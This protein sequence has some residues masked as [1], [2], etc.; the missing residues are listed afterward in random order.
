[1][2]APA[3]PIAT[4]M[5][6]IVIRVRYCDAHCTRPGR[7]VGTTWWVVK[8]APRGTQVLM[9]YV[10]ILSVMALAQAEPDTKEHSSAVIQERI[11]CAAPPMMPW[12]ERQR[13]GRST[14]ASSRWEVRNWN[15]RVVI[16]GGK[17]TSGRFKRGWCM[18]L[19]MYMKSEVGATL[20][21]KRRDGDLSRGGKRDAA[22][23]TE[24]KEK[25]LYTGAT[26]RGP[27][28]RAPWGRVSDNVRPRHARYFCG[29]KQ[30]WFKLSFVKRVRAD[31]ESTHW[32]T[33]QAVDAQFGPAQ[34]VARDLVA[35]DAERGT[36]GQRAS[37]TD[38]SSRN[39]AR[40]TKQ[41]GRGKDL[42]CQTVGNKC[43]AFGGIDL[44]VQMKRWLPQAHNLGL[45]TWLAPVP[46][47]IVKAESLRVD[48]VPICG[49]VC[50]ATACEVRRDFQQKK[51][52]PA[53]TI[54]AECSRA[55]GQK[56]I[57][58]PIQR[59][60]AA[61]TAYKGYGRLK[62][63]TGT[64]EHGQCGMLACIRTK[65]QRAHTKGRATTARTETRNENGDKRSGMFTRLRAKNR[66]PYEGP[67]PL[68]RLVWR[69]GTETG[70]HKHRHFRTEERLEL[71][72][73]ER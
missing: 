73:P 61:A 62:T 59:V 21:W 50:A 51:R 71:E 36:G 52:V 32:R 60:V 42:S 22:G 27:Y 35:M 40:V 8:G 55:F 56:K 11:R 34:P 58:A 28:K 19:C 49:A 47:S 41:L 69:F 67:L 4:R 65:D 5:C 68:R 64:Y 46:A 70:V 20:V 1:M 6:A 48:V 24:T 12:L 18:S 45:K 38:P 9:M 25:R 14:A 66:R 33:N 15:G 30:L 63:G 37:V 53:G 16:Y 2:L 29:K 10:R 54:S 44:T 13:H 26:V 7:D 3:G 31:S 43:V 72:R 17:K 39:R 57:G 23:R